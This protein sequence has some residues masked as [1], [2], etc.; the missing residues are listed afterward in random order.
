L[1]VIAPVRSITMFSFW[2]WVRPGVGLRCAAG[3]V[4]LAI[5]MQRAEL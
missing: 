2:L 5:L 3:L 1:N 4:F